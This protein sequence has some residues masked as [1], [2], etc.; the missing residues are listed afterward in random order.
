MFMRAVR[1]QW[2][3]VVITAT[4]L[5]RDSFLCSTEH[6]VLDVIVLQHRPAS[7]P[8]AYHL[9]T[10]CNKLIC[11]CE[12][13]HKKNT[14]KIRQQMNDGMGAD[15]QA[16]QARG[17]ADLHFSLDQRTQCSDGGCGELQVTETGRTWTYDE[18]GKQ[19]IKS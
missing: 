6:Q 5:H 9:A 8:G 13:L 7:H 17:L 14:R 3:L 18:T 16:E 12:H 15:H 19:R 10:S 4:A 2:L 1:D 11:E